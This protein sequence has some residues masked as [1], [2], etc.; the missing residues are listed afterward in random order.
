MPIASQIKGTL[1]DAA[2]LAAEPRLHEALRKKFGSKPFLFESCS[3]NDIQ[4]LLEEAA[5]MT[6]KEVRKAKF[7][8]VQDSGCMRHEDCSRQL[9]VAVK[10]LEECLRSAKQADVSSEHLEAARELVEA[11][12]GNAKQEGDSSNK[13]D[14]AEAQE[15]AAEED[16]GTG[17]AVEA[18]ADDFVPAILNLGDDEEELVFDLGMGCPAP[19]LPSGVRAFRKSHDR[20]TCFSLSDPFE[21]MA[22]GIIKHLKRMY[23][24]KHW[25]LD[26]LRGRW[27]PKPNAGPHK[28]RECLPLIV[29]LRQR[30]KYALTYREVKMI[31]MQRLIKVDGKVRTDMF[32]PAGFMDVDAKS[33]KS[34]DEILQAE[35]DKMQQT[36]MG[37]KQA[38]TS[39][40]DMPQKFGYDIGKVDRSLASL[41]KQSK[42]ANAYDKQTD[43]TKLVIEV[44]IEKTKENFRL[45]YNTK[46]RF[47][48]HKV[49]KE[50][51]AYKLCRVKRVTRGPRGTPYA[52]T[53]DG[54]TLRFP[55]PD[56]KANDTVRLDLD[57]SKIMDHLKFEVGNTVMVSGGNNIGR[58]GTITQREKH[59]GSFEIIHIKDSAGHSFNTRLENVFVI[60]Q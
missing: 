3:E 53:H 37:L 25:M 40:P 35:L 34:K 44:Q 54:R 60:G 43:F 32:Y 38:L 19:E 42:E 21:T 58:V 16:D 5:G 6:P 47:V 9:R 7:K 22:R 23:A 14:A 36:V 13:D 17:E 8:F 26:K 57:T 45:L 52:V 4:V 12:S 29:M 56:V 1:A 20:V 31:V 18:A 41:V 15:S 27:A 48:L 10:E 30:L 39:F 50:E 28:L 59:P 2:L 46:G 33:K 24:P 55:D 51:A 49:A 11:S